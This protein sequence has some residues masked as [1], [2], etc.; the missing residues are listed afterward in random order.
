MGVLKKV[1]YFRR[2]TT[3]FILVSFS[4]SLMSLTILYFEQ[5]RLQKS[6]DQKEAISEL[7]LKLETSHD[8][9]LQFKNLLTATIENRF[10]QEYLL[11]PS[12]TNYHDAIESFRTI[13]WSNPHIMQL[14]YIDEN[15]NEK[16]RFDRSHINAK[17][18]EIA[19]NKLQNKAS[20]N[21]FK[22]AMQ[23]KESQLYISKLDLNVEHNKI[24]IPYKPVIRFAMPLFSKGKAKG[25]VI[26]NIFMQEYLTMLIRS[27]MFYFYIYDKK[28]CLL[29]SNNPKIPSWSQYLGAPCHFDVHA[30]IDSDVIFPKL[31]NEPIYLGVGLMNSN[32]FKIH[33]F[34]DAIIILSLILIPLS[35]IL[36]YFLSRIPKRLFDA[37]EEQQKMLIQQSKLAAMGEMLASIAHQWRQPL[38]AVGVLTQEVQFK[39]K[40][41]LLKESEIDPLTEQI[42]THLDYM[43]NT[44]NDF[45]DFF[46][47]SKSKEKFDIRDTIHQSLAIVKTKL[48][49]QNIQTII[50]DQHHHQDQAYQTC[51]YENELRQVIINILTNACDAIVKRVQTKSDIKGI[52]EIEMSRTKDNITLQISDNGGGIDAMVIQKIF[53][54][55][56]STKEEQQG[57]GLGLY[58]SKLIIEKN[59]QGTLDAK[60]IE[61]GARF[62]I[63]LPVCEN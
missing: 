21:Y 62:T 8:L 14:R 50:T 3:L 25:I 52:I 1:N 9:S 51:G 58:M 5:S 60:N 34:K 15:G 6:L 30:L 57:T 19:K 26:V 38:N 39:L 63:V 17:P 4:L 35:F 53:E 41:G 45:R 11:H 28:Q 13:T 49:K 22:A 61:T 43:S 56:I 47:P 20:R 2:F 44:I 33:D 48:K 46:K 18:K 59:M 12:A 24:E 29:V 31:K 23:R 55:Y 16:I 10:F 54:P 37:I 7:A 40:R 42:Q 36:A 32:P 27:D